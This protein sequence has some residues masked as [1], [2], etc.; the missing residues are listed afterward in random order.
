MA[1][2]NADNSDEES[3]AEQRVEEEAPAFPFDASKQDVVIDFRAA[4]AIP[5]DPDSDGVK[6]LRAIAFG[7][8]KGVH[9][10]KE[11]GKLYVCGEWKLLT[12]LQKV[13]FV[14]ST[15]RQPELLLAF[16]DYGF[17]NSTMSGVS[18]ET[19]ALPL[20]IK[21]GVYQTAT[22]VTRI[23]DVSGFSPI[24]LTSAPW[25]ITLKPALAKKDFFKKNSMYSPA[26]IN[27]WLSSQTMVQRVQTLE[28]RTRVEMEASIK[29]MA[30][31]D[32]SQATKIK[33][34]FEAK[35]KTLMDSIAQL[36]PSAYDVRM[37]SRVFE[38]VEGRDVEKDPLWLTSPVQKCMREGSS[39]FTRTRLV[40]AALP[41]PPIRE[42]VEP[43]PVD[44]AGDQA[45]EAAAQGTGMADLE[46]SDD[47][48]DDDDG[49][50][51]LDILEPRLASQ[52][53]RKAPKR[54]DPIAPVGQKPAKVAK[55]K[56]NTP[57]VAPA[58]GEKNK[59]GPYKKNVQTAAAILAKAERAAL[60]KELQKA[61][62]KAEVAS[63][64]LQLKA[65]LE[66]KRV[67][68]DKLK[69]QEQMVKLQIDKARAEGEK[70]GMQ[71]AC[72]EYKKG[73]AA[74]AAIASGKPFHFSSTGSSPRRGG[75][76]SS[77]S[78]HYSSGNPF[79]NM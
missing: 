46:L 2:A 8:G 25:S 49:G 70:I 31:Q 15:H 37:G 66:G 62:T 51:E 71:N 28:K 29:D 63:L 41:P 45:P 3:D 1:A 13:H 68:E 59:R 17:A 7:K 22:K 47:D 50:S 21:N 9:A 34:V 42:P 39:K 38:L 5:F 36:P 16:V 75:V 58:A 4:C 60:K 61:D 24:P 40:A 69:D 57:G 64:K 20:L 48:D 30:R 11:A 56:G 55:A 23:E 14:S 73:I 35:L 27:K 43:I 76:P 77:A 6:S 74:G 65:A 53:Q 32:P 79:E 33:A 67:A 19:L 78:T 10:P 72:E 18:V 54:L 26:D 12:S 52:R 44:V